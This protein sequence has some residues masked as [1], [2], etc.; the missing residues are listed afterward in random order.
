MSPVRQ[1]KFKALLEKTARVH[2]VS[3]DMAKTLLP[4]LKEQEKIFIN[5]PSIDPAYFK[6]ESMAAKENMGIILSVGRIFFQKGFTNGLFTMRL[7][8]QMQV[9]FKWIIAGTGAKQEELVFKIHQLGLQDNIELAGAI[10]HATVKKLLQRA[11][12]FYLPS[13]YEGIANVALEAMSMELPVVATRSGG[14]E[15]VITHGYDGML[16]DIFDF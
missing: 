16:A 7:L 8:K 1:R 2:C 5:Y 4:Y 6:S 12:V 11:T 14:M 10:P 9:H 13:V 15:E 3:D